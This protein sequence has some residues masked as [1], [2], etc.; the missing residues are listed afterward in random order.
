[1]SRAEAERVQRRAIGEGLPR[2]TFT[3]NFAQ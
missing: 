1:M 2:D 3:R